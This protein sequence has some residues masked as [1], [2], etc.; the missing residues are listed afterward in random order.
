M[1]RRRKRRLLV[2]E[3]GDA[4]ERLKQSV[5]VEKLN[6]TATVP[7]GEVDNPAREAAKS[8]GIPYK[9]GDNGDMKAREAGAIGGQ[10]GGSMVK[11]LIQL[12][13]QE[14]AK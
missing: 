14:L 7:R 4:L 9:T 3:A 6:G 13:K 10:I 1:A 2:P 5:V 11:R 8:I 12:A